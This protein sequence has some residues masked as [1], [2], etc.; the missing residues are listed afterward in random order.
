MASTAAK[1]GKKKKEYSF[2]F[3]NN[4]MLIQLALILALCLFITNA[5]SKRAKENAK[6]HLAAL[7][8]E[9][10]VII[11]DY[12]SNAE[13]ILQTFASSPQFVQIL[14]KDMS[15]SAME[16]QMN[17]E[18]AQKYV[19]EYAAGI[20]GLE[21]LYVCD[22]DAKTILHSNTATV[23]KVI[24][25]G[26]RLSSL[27]ASLLAVSATVYNDGILISP[28]SGKQ[29]VSLYRGIFDMEGNPLGFAGLAVDTDALMEKLNNMK[30]PGLT[31]AFFSLLDVQKNVYIFD[32]Q[33]AAGTEITQPDLV[34]TCNDVRGKSESISGTY[35]Y[36]AGNMKVIGT[37]E[38]LPNRQWVLLMNAN[39]R[40]VYSLVNAMIMFMVV[41]TG[42]M[43][44][45]MSLFTYLNRK[46]ARVNERL[47]SSIDKIKETK[48]SL[49]SAMYNDVLTDVGNRIKFSIDV[50]AVEDARTNPYYFALFNIID[51]S[52]INTGFGND[53]GDSLLSR[54]AEILKEKFKAT[55]IYRTGSDEFVVMLKTEN[56]APRQEFVIDDV[57]ECLR[58]LIL[59]EEVPGVG[60]LY[61]KYR[62]AVIKKN[63]E[64]DTSVVT[65]MKEMTKIKG[66]AMLGMIDF[67]DLSDPNI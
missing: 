1:N 11:D 4:F 34:K 23:G 64:I 38:Y 21:G 67:S 6:E 66:E 18:I 12:V 65:V 29:V 13:T 20:P 41:F 46:Q 51:F 52:S 26:D 50:S 62:V 10:A 53:A 25:E 40:E 59:P 37:Y 49:S 24:R 56:G 22:W 43:A 63:S 35:E 16:Q 5:I 44:G 45:M 15:G 58:K 47:L 36:N 3:L 32:A 19:T 14:N 39:K 27:R 7:G 54:T 33:E 57:N 48:Q 28:N 61:P 17:L 2:K 8:S 60:T 30:T 55:D 9:H 31:T 42:L